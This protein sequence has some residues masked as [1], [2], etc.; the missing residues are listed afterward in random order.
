MTRLSPY[1]DG[2]IAAAADH[3]HHV[4]QH[5]VRQTLSAVLDVAPAASA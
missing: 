1:M 3:D 5:I 4:D 2:Y